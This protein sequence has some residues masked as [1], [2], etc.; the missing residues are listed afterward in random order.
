ML[1]RG[2]RAP[3]IPP[4]EISHSDQR[5]VCSVA[6]NDVTEWLQSFSTMRVQAPLCTIQLR[7]DATDLVIFEIDELN[8]Y[9][10]YEAIINQFQAPV[11]DEV[12]T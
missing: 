10:Y 3:F 1:G 11:A 8:R 12:F 2:P 7:A 5:L 6:R 9:M 4:G